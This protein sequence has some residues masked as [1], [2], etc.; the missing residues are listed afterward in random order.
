MELREVLTGNEH[1]FE[2]FKSEMRDRKLPENYENKLFSEKLFETE[3]E[4]STTPYYE[5]IE[6]L[7]FYPVNLSLQNCTIRFFLS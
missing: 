5:L 7:D 3:N 1:D 2:L 6:L 4:K